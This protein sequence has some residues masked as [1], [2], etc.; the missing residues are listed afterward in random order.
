MPIVVS[1]PTSPQAEP[2]PNVQPSPE[3]SQSPL[4]YLFLTTATNP[5]QE[6]KESQSEPELP[7][8]HHEPPQHEESKEVNGAV[9]AVH[10]RD[11]TPADETMPKARKRQQGSSVDASSDSASQTAESSATSSSDGDGIVCLK[12]R[13]KMHKRQTKKKK[14]LKT[15]HPGSSEEDATDTDGETSQQTSTDASSEDNDRSAKQGKKKHK[16]CK[17][18]W[19]SDSSDTQTDTDVD[20]AATTESADTSQRT[21][22]VSAAEEEEGLSIADPNWSISED[23]LLRGMKTDKSGPS[24]REIARTLKKSQTDCKARWNTIKGSPDKFQDASSDEDA[25][26][27]QHKSNKGKGKEQSHDKYQPKAAKSKHSKVNE[28]T[29]RR[30]AS[31]TNDGLIPHVAEENR[32]DGGFNDHTYGFGDVE[33]RQQNQYWHEHI[34][35]TLYPAIVH[36]VPDAYLSKQDC[37]VLSA[38]QSKHHH[39]KWLEMQANFYNVTGR[40]IPLFIIRD[41]CERAE[42]D[43]RRQEER[44]RIEQW[45]RRVAR[46]K[47]GG[48]PA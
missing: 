3:A 21:T 20:T 7:S 40:M 41:R 35:A 38:C 25:P 16:Q 24:W 34:L 26:P 1:P 17:F 37:D 18:R 6:Q 15:P 2:N 43:R 46:E 36:P 9:A 14:K 27:V 30:A 31:T 4:S 45:A 42:E 5:P 47:Q 11:S 19:V 10:D 28:K 32:E 44:Q 29:R 23:A 22:S 39:S 33:R 12:L 13:D 48:H 8:N